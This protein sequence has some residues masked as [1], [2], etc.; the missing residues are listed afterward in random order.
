MKIR[1]LAIGA[2]ALLIPFGAAACGSDSKSSGDRPSVSELEKAFSDE[3]GDDGIAGDASK[4]I[5]EKLHKSSMPDDILRAMVDGDEPE[6]SD[7]D[8]A[9]Y[10]EIVDEAMNE[11]VEEMIGDLDPDDLDLDDLEGFDEE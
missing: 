4:C 8:E 7:A 3:V 5:A 6:I 9:K 11:C 2:L 10:M 1:S